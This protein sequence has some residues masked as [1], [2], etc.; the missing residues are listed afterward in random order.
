MSV[1]IDKGYE[2]LLPWM[3]TQLGGRVSACER[4]GDRRSGGRPAFFIDVERPD[5]ELVRTYAR[6]NRGQTQS[7]VF[8]LGR[9]HAVLEELHS[10]GIAVPEPLGHCPDPDGIL[11]ERLTGEFDYALITDDAQQDAIDRAFVSEIAKVHALDTAPFEARG[12]SAPTTRDE[13]ALSDLVQ[14]EKAFDHGVRHP[15]PLVRFARNWLHHNIPDAPER[16]VLIQG[17][18]GPGQFMYEGNKLTGI[19]DWEF[20]HIADPMLDLAQIRIRDWYNPGADMKKWLALYTEYSG[21]P[22][23]LKRLRYY[24][25]KAMIITPL[26]LVGI[27]QNM[28]PQTDHAEWYAQD[29]SYKRGLIE[30]VAEAM[31]IVLEPV[32]LP[33]PDA[34]PR[35][36]IF[37]ILEQN[38]REELP[39]A[40]RDD[41]ARYRAGLAARMA[42]YAR[43]IDRY[44]AAFEAQERD[45]MGAILGSTPAS[46]ADGHEALEAFVQTAAG[47]SDADEAL[48]RYFHHHAT[49]EEALMAGA[50]G[51]G[52]GASLQPV[53]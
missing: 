42:T 35:A 43:N 2:A 15:V 23:D 45:E 53:V 27:V 11:L 14:W 51:A 22:V 24:S 10:A 41:F 5:G 1:S 47:G 8:T 30:T 37:E 32:E 3:E 18:T 52:E 12:F 39:A 17:D 25:V 9:E 49:R 26:A 19:V 46:V 34:S 44:G 40:M 36:P 16:A 4:Q 38:V 50:L 29:I 21:T 48:V 20:A 33:K 6:M 13:F 31:D 7:G 28:H